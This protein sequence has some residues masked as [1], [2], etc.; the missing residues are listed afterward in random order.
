M[1]CTKGSLNF[2]RHFV[3]NVNVFRNIETM[4]SVVILFVAA[5]VVVVVVAR[6]YVILTRHSHY[7][8]CKLL[9]QLLYKTSKHHREVCYLKNSLSYLQWSLSYS[10]EADS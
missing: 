7:E 3:Y 2:V 5:A 1:R 4:C 6:I 9:K 8:N 10:S